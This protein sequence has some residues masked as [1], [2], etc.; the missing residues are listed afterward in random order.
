MGDELG[1]KN[2]LIRSPLIRS[3]P[4]P[5]TSK[6]GL[7]FGWNININTPWKRTNVDLKRDYLTIGSIH[8]NQPLIFRGYSLVPHRIRK[9]SISTYMIRWFF[10]GK[11]VGKYRIVP[12]ILWALNTIET[13]SVLWVDFAPVS[14]QFNLKS[15]KPFIY[16]HEQNI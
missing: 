1:W 11:L 6:P 3:L 16:K 5:G 2:P 10:V 8:L 13:L 12:W 4:A 15:W 14:L 9:C 7:G